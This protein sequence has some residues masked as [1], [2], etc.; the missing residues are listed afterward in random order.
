MQGSLEEPYSKVVS[1]PTDEVERNRW[2][3]AMPNERSSLLQLKQIY[4]CANHF[5]CE[6]ISV[7]GGKRPSQPPSI[8]PGVLKSCLKQVS[9]APRTRPTTA[10][11]EARAE[12]ER[13][14]SLLQKVDV[15]TKIFIYLLPNFITFLQLHIK[16]YE[17][18]VQLFYREWNC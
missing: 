14:C 3:D 10:S 2:I 13:Y 7:K 8:F 15:L 12:K 4:A 5:D 11:A 18:P 9:S 1:F 16:G 17:S 6:W